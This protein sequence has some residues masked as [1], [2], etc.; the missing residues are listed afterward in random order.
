MDVFI[1]F[2]F[3]SYIIILFFFSFFLGEYH[4]TFYCH[5]NTVVDVKWSN[6]DTMLLTSGADYRIH[7]MD[8][9]TQFCL[10]SF[11]GH[12]AILRSSNW[13]PTDSRKKKKK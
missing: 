12:R 11:V 8:V 7:I 10:A 6:D 13:H 2:Y 4:T 9:E 5:S 1:I 3:I